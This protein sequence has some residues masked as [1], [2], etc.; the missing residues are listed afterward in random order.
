MVLVNPVCAASPIE[1]TVDSGR[2]IGVNDFSVASKLD[3][4]WER[5]RDSSTLRQLAEDAGFKLVAFYVWKRSSP[6]A[7]SYWYESTKTG[8]FDWRDVDS[9][10]R[11]IF[12]IGAEP[13]L[14][15]CGYDMSSQ[16]LPP[17]M[18]TNPS[19]GLPYPSSWAAYSAEWVKHFKAVGL[20]VKYYE[21]TTE[22]FKYFGWTADLTKLSHYVKLWNAAARAMRAVSPKI[23]LSQD[24]I[25]AQRVLDY[26]LKYGDNV[27]FLDFHKYDSYALEGAGYYSN[28]ELLRRAETSRFVTTSGGTYGVDEA[29]QKWF[30]ARG[31][32]LPVINSE[33]NLNSAWKDG[34]D[35]RIQK[36][37][38][39]VWTALMLRM[40]ILKGLSYSAYFSFGSNARY[41][42]TGN[43]FGMINL[44]NNRPWYPYYVHKWLGNNL[45][46]GD[47]LVESTSSSNDVRPLAWINNKKLNVLIISKVNQYK[48]LNIHGV[49]GQ[50]KYYKIDNTI[51]YLTPQVQT[52]T[53]SPGTPLYLTGYTVILLQSDASTP[54][55][56]P[57]GIIFEDGF[58]SGDF[59][60]WTGTTTTSGETATV[61]SYRPYSGNYHGRFTSNGGSGVERAY[62]YKDIGQT[63][64]IYVRSYVYIQRGLPLL[65]ENDRFNFFAIKGARR[66]SVIAS[67]SVQHT[68]GTDRWTIRSHDG[69]WSASTGPSMYQWYCVEFYTK[70]D[71]TNGIHRLW[72]NGQI[73][74]EQT[75][76]N[77]ATEGNIDSV[78]FGLTYLNGVTSSVN[79]YGD[80]FVVSPTY[81]GPEQPLLFEDG[82]ESGDFSKWTGTTTTSGETATVAS[83][84]PYSGNYHG[85]FTSNGGSGVE[86]GY[87]FKTLNE[88]KVYARGYFRVVRGLPLSDNNDRFYLIRFRAGDQSLTG[89]GIRRYNGVERWMVYGRDG[90]S[91]VWPT[92]V[93]SPSIEM[94]RWYCIELDWQKHASQGKIEVYIDGQKIFEITGINTSYFGN[95]N[96]VQFGLINDAGVQNNLI[97]Y[98]DSSAISKTYIG[99]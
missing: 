54:P 66:G 39:A 29:R 90:S 81:I 96:S 11:R 85:R 82:F 31:K 49:Q 92:Y 74:I 86:H 55:P 65:D 26:W 9:L 37:V 16:Y 80:S 64:E 21:I 1:V 52:G 10:V 51:S 89:V 46:V 47:I 99:P 4:E 69:I 58:E 59:S 57:S 32:L 68:G 44:D 48:T 25:T 27:D 41:T 38:G 87:S 13:L 79:V 28:A 75:S 23:L 45:K 76:L 72:I 43:G 60:K 94:N 84:R 62:S 50:I 12:E 7:C 14:S 3:Y 36:M 24:F 63:S 61:A 83:Y 40:S 78:R 35:P 2:S 19:T 71:A 5:W 95:V 77:T 70:I 56:P 93:T 53:I 98:V 17:G 30:N 8:R 20:P 18:A 6:R 73:I 88:E 15:L 33:C 34:T 22:P 42:R 67:V 91:W 97:V